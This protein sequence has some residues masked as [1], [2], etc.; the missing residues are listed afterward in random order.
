MK[1]AFR[2][3]VYIFAAIGFML[4]AG[5]FAVKFGLTNEW[6]TIDEQRD[7]FLRSGYFET[8]TAWASTTI[9]KKLMPWREIEEWQVIKEALIKDKDVLMRAAQDAGVNPRII[10]AQVAVEQLRL[11][12]TNRELF[13]NVFAPLKILGTQSQFSWGVV[14][15]KE[16]TAIEV[17]KH[18][19]DPSS[20]FYPGKEYAHLL[21][22]T[23]SN[24]NEERF[25]R[26]IDENDR[27]YSYL[28]AGLHIKQLETQWKNAGYDISKRP[29]ILSTLFNIGFRYSKPH[30]NPKSGGASISING[31]QYSFGSLAGE[32]Y[33][34]SELADIFPK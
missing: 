20:P 31:T 21:D 19:K 32:F 28:Y 11:F 3:I 34:S 16:E 22:F 2:Y 30:A 17:E 12:T 26:I 10:A 29:E 14:G 4:T 27:Y 15:I 7:A 25:M 9:E 33:N 24:P 23:T 6:G 18:L 8:Q 13:K 1:T 5:Y